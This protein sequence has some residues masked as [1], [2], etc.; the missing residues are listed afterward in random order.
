MDYVDFHD[1]HWNE[2]PEQDNP[3]LNGSEPCLT[4]Y[5]N[6]QSW[7]ADVVITDSGGAMTKLASFPEHKDALEYCRW[8][9]RKQPLTLALCSE[10][11]QNVKT[12]KHKK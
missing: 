3:Q 9:C 11:V 5:K 7:Y 6:R 12:N 10:T 2:I 4:I 1:K 8:R